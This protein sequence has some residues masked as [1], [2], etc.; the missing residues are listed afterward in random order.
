MFSPI[1]RLTG[2]GAINAR[3]G[4]R[5]VDAYTLAF[6]EKYLNNAAAPLLDGASVDYPEVTLEKYGK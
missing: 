2:A 1:H 4:L 6:F 3:R 5:I